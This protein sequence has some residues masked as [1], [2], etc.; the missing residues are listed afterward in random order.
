V[1]Y[2][3]IKAADPEA[4]VLMGGVAYDWFLEYGGP[5]F[6]Y[7]PDS[8]M[9]SGGAEYF[10]ALNFHYFPDFY[11][12]WERWDPASED[13]LN[14][15]LP[16][17]TCGDLFD[18]LGT[19]YEA[20]GID[21]IAKAN[22]FRNRMD[23]CFGVDKPIWLTELGE[24]GRAGDPNSLAQQARYVIQGTTRGLA[25]GIQ[26]ITWFV[27]VSPPYDAHEQGLLYED[28]WSPKPAY[29]A[30]QTLTRELAGYTYSHTL[31][32]LD[33][34]G[35]VFRD[36]RGQE[37]TVAWGSGRV[38]FAPASLLRI[39]DRGGN[40]TVVEDGSAGDMDGSQNG[41]VVL[42]MVADPVFVLR[43]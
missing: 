10:D 35:Y 20:G 24:H 29:Y 34:E 14:G 36:D 43:W 2:E 27:L 38:T 26:N 40:V 41:E 3:A 28:D 31:D 7:F 1:A 4:T 15:W 16:A 6:R 12:E 37:K 33:V 9:A 13:R 42:Q 39:V 23:T 19:A 5:F 30:Y 17:P 21:L 8:V 18:G 11:R 32:A 25:A 22:H